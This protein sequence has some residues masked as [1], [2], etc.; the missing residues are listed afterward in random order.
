[1]HKILIVNV[2][3]EENNAGVFGA[4][5]SFISNMYKLLLMKIVKN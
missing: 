3:T 4:T 1:M 2:I 5:V